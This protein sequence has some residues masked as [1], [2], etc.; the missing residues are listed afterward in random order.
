VNDIK[1]IVVFHV[2]LGPLGLWMM[3][4]D[5][6]HPERWGMWNHNPTYAIPFC[7]AGDVFI[8]CGAFYIWWTVQSKKRRFQAGIRRMQEANR[9]REKGRYQEAAR[10]FEEGLRLTGQK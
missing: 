1:A 2:V 4:D 3:A 10:A 7:I 6:H 8:W 5:M 9:L